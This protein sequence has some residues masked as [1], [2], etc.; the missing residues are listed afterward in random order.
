MCVSVR[1]C[2]RVCVCLCVQRERESVCVHTL[3]VLRD[4]MIYHT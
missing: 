4:D 1:E 2:E 3:V